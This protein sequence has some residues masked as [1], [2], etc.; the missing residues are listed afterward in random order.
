MLSRTPFGMR[1]LR[2]VLVTVLAVLAAGVVAV[3]SSAPAQAAGAPLSAT[4]QKWRLK[5][6][7]LYVSAEID[8]S[9]NDAGKLRA[10]TTS[11]GGTEEFT[12]H[13]DTGGDTVTI[14]SQANGLYVSSEINDSGDH[15]GMLRA[16]G[17]TTGSWER[18][19]V[20]PGSD[21]SYALKSAANGKY[22]TAEFNFT[23]DDEGLLRARS[24]TV[25]SWE[26]ITL[27]KA[28]GTGSTTA[29]PAP[30]GTAGGTHHVTSWNVCADHNGS[31]S[32][33]QAT[34]S[35][36][37]DTIAPQIEKNGP[38]AVFLQEFCEKAAKPL[39]LRLEQDTG[40]GWDVRFAPVYLEVSGASGLMAQKNCQNDT[41]GVDRGAFGIAVA[42]PD[43][44]TWYRAY[45]L[46]S[47]T[48]KQQRPALCATV[49]SKGIAYCGTH[50]SSGGAN[51]DDPDG[52]WRKK[53][54]DSLQADIQG[55]QQAGF[56]P[57]FGGDLNV[58][59]PDSST[60]ENPDVRSTLT[61]LYA[62]YHE[63]DQPAADSPRS[64]DP[65]HGTL[66]IDYVFGSKAASYAC[67]VTDSSASD[68]RLISAT[69]TY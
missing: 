63:C 16:R 4:G 29:P 32:L 57:L 47:P 66:K 37:T 68:H 59:P 36:I 55:V 5:V 12:L 60:I 14:R 43:E 27:E 11:P 42:V 39:E 1:R 35:R 13:T 25:G 69:V 22:V 65:T 61:A 52:T 34:S 38:E 62:S 6:N 15:A 9:G 26:R 53:Q 48:G 8:A 45:L 31:C 64:G 40:L 23:G 67:T 30:S 18:F 44:N 49:P 54:A 7:G 20:V 3:S 2:L 21:G 50:F 10:R 56:E 58:I 28:G 33:D 46:P 19:E 24:D 41:A 17:T 51:W